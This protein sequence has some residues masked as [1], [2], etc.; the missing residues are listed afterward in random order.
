MSAKRRYVHVLQIIATMLIIALLG[1]CSVKAPTTSPEATIGPEPSQEIPQP[2]E[3]LLP[4]ATVQPKVALVGF[5]TNNSFPLET[6]QELIQKL[7]VENGMLV[8]P[9]LNLD[10]SESVSSA[11]IL[12]VSS[13]VQGIGDFAAHHPAMKILV[14][15]KTDLQPSGN[16]FLVGSQGDLWDERGFIAG[17]LASVITQD[18]RA[19]LITQMDSEAGEAVKVGF[20][21]GFVFYCGLCR[22]VYPPFYIY[23]IQSELPLDSTQEMQQAAADLLINSAVETVYVQGTIATNWLYEYLAQEGIRII[24]DQP[25]IP[26]AEGQ[27]AA[28]LQLDLEEAL[29]TAWGRMMAGE[30]GTVVPAALT[31][32]STNEQLFSSAR[33]RLVAETLE[34]IH[35]GLIDT[36]YKLDSDG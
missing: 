7:T 31:V 23:P 35:Q 12:V 16:L 28:S 2:T 8:E 15:G 32:V 21:N 4:T 1:A 19:G 22:Q 13:Q 18:W 36:G 34:E 29:Q 9:Y 10:A 24:A 25:P 6:V 3:T 11:Q 30:G 20:T 33:L 5:D 26:G 27:W 17:Y 14:V